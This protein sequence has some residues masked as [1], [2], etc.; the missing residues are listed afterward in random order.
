MAVRSLLDDNRQIQLAVPVQVRRR[1]IVMTGD[2]VQRQRQPRRDLRIELAVRIETVGMIDRRRVA[3]AADIAQ[4]Q[5]V[6]LG[7]LA[8]AEFG[9]CRGRAHE[10]LDRRG[11]ADRLVDDPHARRPVRLRGRRWLAP[12]FLR[13]F[14]FRAPSLGLKRPQIVN[15]IPRVIRLDH[16][17]KGRH[18]CPVN[19]RHE[20]LIKI[21]VRRTALEARIV[22]GVSEV[23]GPNRLLF[24]VSQGRSRRPVAAPLLA[25][26]VTSALAA[27]PTLAGI[28]PFVA[29]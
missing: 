6:A 13:Q 18:R 23:V 21:L 2:G 12:R 26:G 17:R 8:S 11:P 20:D 27:N 25:L 9:V 16:I 19:A 3:I 28:A 10:M 24:A 4:H 5:P 7:N 15:Q 14:C 22:G 29:E 1:E